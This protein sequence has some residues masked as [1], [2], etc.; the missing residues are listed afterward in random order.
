M[1]LPTPFLFQQAMSGK[2][3]QH[4]RKKLHA[5]GFRL[6]F[7][8]GRVRLHTLFSRQQTNVLELD[9]QYKLDMNMQASCESFRGFC[10]TTLPLFLSTADASILRAARPNKPWKLETGG[11]REVLF[12]NSWM[13][14]QSVIRFQ[15]GQNTRFSSQ[16]HVCS[17]CF[18]LFW[19]AP[20]HLEAQEQI[21]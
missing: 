18:R 9:A 10:F 5:L 12:L 13:L 17:A 21:C 16:K 8:I 19:D 15:P 20:Q 2:S 14:Q 3:C 11:H 1:S 6:C 4:L 7:A